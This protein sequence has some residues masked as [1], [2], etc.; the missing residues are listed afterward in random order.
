MVG[1]RPPRV[2]VEGGD[3]IDAELMQHDGTPKGIAEAAAKSYCRLLC[4]VPR[5]V[6]ASTWIAGRVTHCLVRV[7]MQLDFKAEE[8]A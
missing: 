8:V 6:L 5:K 2:K 7:G 3:W 1:E 4:Y